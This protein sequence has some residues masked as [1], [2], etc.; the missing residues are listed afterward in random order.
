MK[1]A[2]KSKSFLYEICIEKDKKVVLLL[3]TNQTLTTLF[4]SCIM[5]INLNV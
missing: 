3:T 5:C 2:W 4:M 1:K